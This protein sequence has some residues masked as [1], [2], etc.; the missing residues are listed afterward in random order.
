M[1]IRE[2]GSLLNICNYTRKTWEESKAESKEEW[3]N[4][5][6]NLTR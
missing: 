2:N 1:F 3:K 6:K 4:L 5:S